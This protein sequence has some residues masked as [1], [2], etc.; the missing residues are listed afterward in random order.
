MNKPKSD[1]NKLAAKLAA[2]I[3]R[4]TGANAQEHQALL[5]DLKQVL[6]RHAIRRVSAMQGVTVTQYVIDMRNP[7]PRH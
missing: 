4:T 1:V 2:E 5:D 3:E 7:S 6:G